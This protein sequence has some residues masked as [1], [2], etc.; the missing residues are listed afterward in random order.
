[1]LLLGMTGVAGSGGR[2]H[3]FRHVIHHPVFTTV[4]TGRLVLDDLL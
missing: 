2:A 1:M 3:E 4:Y